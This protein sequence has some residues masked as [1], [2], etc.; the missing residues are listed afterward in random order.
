MELPLKIKILKM[1]FL[2]ARAGLNKMGL[3][4]MNLGL[5]MA[6]ISVDK[7]RANLNIGPYG[8]PQF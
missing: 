7:H 5:Q 2:H 8:V 1:Y 6:Y 4:F 3:I